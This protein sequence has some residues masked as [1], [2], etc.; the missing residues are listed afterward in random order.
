[1]WNSLRALDDIGIAR[2]ITGTDWYPTSSPGKF[3]AAPLIAGSMLVTGVAL[4]VCVPVGLA[5]AVYVSEFAGRRLKEISKAVIELMAAIPSVVYGLVGVALVVPG[6]K[7]AF[8]LDSGLTA[9]SGGIVLGIMALP[10]IVSISEDA[11]HAVPSALRHASLALG[12]T[13]WQTTYKVTI[14]AASSG[15]FAAVMLGV[16]RAI[17]E[18]MAVL[19]LTGNAAVMPR[20]VLES[21]RTMTGTIAAE[22]GEVVQGGT[23]YSVLFVVGLILFTMAFSINLVADIVLDKQRKRWA[24]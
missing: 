19:M 17:G 3:G 7:K 11:L 10:T 22:M 9:L 23:H 5:A 6:V 24:A 13:R 8:G 12:N 16:G 14:P 18:T 1:M 15:I 21:V 2:I 20:S 4:V